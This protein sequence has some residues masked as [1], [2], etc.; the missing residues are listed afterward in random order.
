VKIRRL[1]ETGGVFLSGYVLNAYGF[2]I[3]SFQQDPHGQK[4]EHSPLRV[5]GKLSGEAIWRGVDLFG[6]PVAGRSV[7]SVA[8]HALTGYFEF[9]TTVKN[10]LSLLSKPDMRKTFIMI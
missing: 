9:G 3:G 6:L 5:C 8:V 2:G 4:G 7:L 1:R 10:T